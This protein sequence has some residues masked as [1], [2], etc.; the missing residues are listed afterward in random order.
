MHTKTLIGEIKAAKGDGPGTFE[1]ILS[2]PT[3]DRD[4]EVLDAHAF[5]PLPKRIPIDVDHGIGTEKT[6]G[7]GVPYYE[8]GVLKIKGTFASTPLGQE[9]RALVTEGH[10]GF[11]SVMYMNAVYEVDEKDGLPHLRKG[12][13]LNAAITPVPSNRQAAITASKS[14]FGFLK[15]GETIEIKARSAKDQ[16]A[17]QSIYNSVVALGAV[18]PGCAEKSAPTGVAKSADTDPEPAAAPA[19]AAPADVDVAMALVELAL[20]EAALT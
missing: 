19:A 9:T 16:N 4:G 7:S 2:M 18:C 12:E 3:V 6:V 14:Q 20:A 5:E 8:D 1:A 17:I 11:M 15:D 13:L 10:V